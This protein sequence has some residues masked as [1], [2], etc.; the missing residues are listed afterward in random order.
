MSTS[1]V[2]YLELAN[3]RVHLSIWSDPGNVLDGESHICT[4]D[5]PSIQADLKTQTV[6]PLCAEV[7]GLKEVP[8]FLS[9]QWLTTVLPCTF[10]EVI[11]LYLRRPEMGRWGFLYTQIFGGLCYLIGSVFMFELWRVHRK[12]KRIAVAGTAQI[13][14]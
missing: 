11:A 5:D 2:Y 4:R 3:F 9:L 7:A 13:P 10:A 8:S 6:G 1:K 14:D 12:K